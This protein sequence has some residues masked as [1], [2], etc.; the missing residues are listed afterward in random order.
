MSWETWTGPSTSR[1][2]SCQARPGGRCTFAAAA[3][4]RERIFGP[5]AETMVESVVAQA[6]RRLWMEYLRY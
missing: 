4:I 6:E 5:L 1:Q 3:A 2:K